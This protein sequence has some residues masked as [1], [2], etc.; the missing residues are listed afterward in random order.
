MA[1][2][3][4]S[5]ASA[6]SGPHGGAFR[7]P[8]TGAN[9]VVASAHYL[10]SLAGLRMLLEGGNAVDA[11]V[12]VAAAL[13]VVEPFMSGVGGSGYMLVYRAASGEHLALDYLGTAP[14]AA[15]LETVRSSDDLQNTPKGALVPGNLAGW[16]AALE[17]FGTLDRAAVFAPAI[18][19][20]EQG[21][22]LPA[23]RSEFF[24]ANAAR[25]LRWGSGAPYL[26]DGRVPRHGELVRQPD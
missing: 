13:N 11:A 6:L 20:A 17:R 9:G 23:R 5:R 18:A 22:P 15:S 3:S 1:T 19:Y 14:R 21:V 12:A 8:V 24:A 7:P 4:I 10:A 2:T 16:L 26:L 25:L